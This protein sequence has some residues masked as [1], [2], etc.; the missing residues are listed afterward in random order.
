[1]P[2]PSRRGKDASGEGRK[3]VLLLDEY[4]AHAP[5]HACDASMRGQ[6][7]MPD[8]EYADGMIEHDGDVGKLL[9]ALDD[10]GIANDTIV[11]YGLY[12]REGQA[13]LRLRLSRDG[14]L[15][16]RPYSPAAEGQGAAQADVAYKGKTEERG[17]SAA[18]TLS[19]NGTKVAEGE[20]PKT[21]PNVISIVERF[22][23]GEDVGSAVDFTYKLPFKFTGTIDKIRI[24]LTG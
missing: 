18:V 4:D 2:S 8:N 10:L 22:D 11:V 7:G 12:V 16:D 23:V 6:S 20:L 15:R 24:D 9:K 1:M 5:L 19:V 21:I 17:K 14:A 13:D 3:T